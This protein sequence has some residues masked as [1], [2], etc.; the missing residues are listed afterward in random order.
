MTDTGGQ[1]AHPGI[2]VSVYRINPETLKRTH[3]SSRKLPALDDP[4]LNLAFPP[5]ECPR[6]R[7]LGASR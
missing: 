2:T 6:C 1:A 3:V 5:C 7:S 4:V